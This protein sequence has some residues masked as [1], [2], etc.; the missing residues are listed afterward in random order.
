M[1]I[2]EEVDHANRC[3]HRRIELLLANICQGCC[4]HAVYEDED[5][6]TVDISALAPPCR[7]RVIKLTGVLM[8]VPLEVVLEA[9]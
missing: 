8:S 7:T 6:F 9:R 4:D 1:Q 2:D 5:Q 3:V